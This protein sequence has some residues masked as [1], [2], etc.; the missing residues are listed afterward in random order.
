MSE[1]DDTFPEQNSLLVNEI[2]ASELDETLS[3]VDDIDR[4]YFVSDL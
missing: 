2:V 1:E 3:E 4:L